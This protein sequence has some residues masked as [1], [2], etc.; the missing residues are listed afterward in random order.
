MDLYDQ[1]QCLKSARSKHE[2][3]GCHRMSSF[4]SELPKGQVAGKSDREKSPSAGEP[5]ANAP[6]HQGFIPFNADEDFLNAPG[7]LQHPF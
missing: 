6:G 5:G 2:R 3:A 4:H 1:K 7:G